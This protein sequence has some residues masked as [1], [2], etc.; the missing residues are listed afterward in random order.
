M[1]HIEFL[2]K[3][4]SID[5]VK[6]DPDS[7]VKNMTS[8]DL[9]ARSC[10]SQNEYLNKAEALNFSPAQKQLLSKATKHVDDS[11]SRLGQLSSTVDL[12]QVAVMTWRFSLMDKN[13]ENSWPHTRGNIIF[14]SN[15]LFTNNYLSICETLAHEKMH[16][17]QRALPDACAIYYMSLG[18]Y[19]IGMRSQ[20]TLSRANP[21][22]DQYVYNYGNVPCFVLYRST[23]PASMDDVESHGP[24]EHP[25]EA[26]AYLVGSMVVDVM[27]K[28]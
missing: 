1:G 14:L 19:R 8:V 10:R 15:K 16:V 6:R 2:S 13:Y 18:Y 25:N 17:F 26:M 23:K 3:E 27:R 12:R 7:Y 21:D 9:Y 28:S 4:Q 11:L 22:L 20:M 24:T 5:F